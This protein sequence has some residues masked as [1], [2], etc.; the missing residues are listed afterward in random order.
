VRG[1][2]TERK[3]GSMRRCQFR[4]SSCAA[5]CV[6][7]R[8]AIVI[9]RSCAC[10]FCA[11]GAQRKLGIGIHPESRR[12]DIALAPPLRITRTSPDAR[13]IDHC[14]RCWNAAFKP[15]CRRFERSLPRSERL[16]S[17]TR[18]GAAKCGRTHHLILKTRKIGQDPRSKAK[19][20]LWLS[21]KQ[22]LSEEI[23][24][25]SRD[26]AANRDAVPIN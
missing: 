12:S 26:H 4:L 17:Q 14:R 11:D 24:A 9:A 19:P 6:K 15:V 20:I 21:C 5:L 2:V 7:A 18:S 8:Y 16:R 3:A 23:P 1:K 10:Q 25:A 22:S 13:P